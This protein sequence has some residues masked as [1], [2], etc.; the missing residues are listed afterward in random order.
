M[1]EKERML[2][3]FETEMIPK[4]YG[5]CRLKMNTVEDAEDL[6]QEISMEVLRAIRGDK[7]IE[8]LNAFVWSVSN[9]LFFNFLRRKK[10]NTTVYL[11][12]CLSDDL[13]VEEDYIRREELSLLR[14]E[15]AHMTGNYRRAVILHYFEERSCEEIAEILCRSVGTV[16]WWLHDARNAIKKG[17]DLMRE[18]GEKSYRPGRLLVSCTGLPGADSEPMACAKRKS[19]QNILLSAYRKPV[20]IE[21]LCVELGIS[22]PYIEDEAEYLVEN[23]LLCEVAGGKYQTDFVILPGDSPTVVDAIREAV[24]PAYYER[25]MTFLEGKRELLTSKALNTSGFSWERL[26]WVYIHVIT[27]IALEKF[28]YEN[29]LHVKY[30][31][32]PLRPN[33]GK[34]IAYGYENDPSVKH[35]QW[36]EYHPYDGPVHKVNGVFAEGFF[37]HWSGTDDAP[38]FET[39]DGVFALCLRIVKGEVSVDKLTEEGKYLFSIAL[40]KKLFVKEDNGYRPTFYGVGREAFVKL[41]ELAVEFGREAED[42]FLCVKDVVWKHYAP[43]VPKDLAWQMGNLLSNHFYSLIT[44]TCHEGVASGV[45]T[46]PTDEGKLWISLIVSENA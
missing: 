27:A 41:N 12:D 34:W 20:S 8:N 18:Y 11:P 13:D 5:F 38:Y 26:L 14:R 32:L 23:Q 24:F 36:K 3:V 22:A 37:H 39:P 7:S 9:H 19:A 46:S 29:N 30:D 21:E 15:L 42:L 10:R 17:M 1:T 45:L 2:Y 33:G 31:D 35:P 4:I 43:S 40:E 28:K 16:K 25:L 6:S 44:C